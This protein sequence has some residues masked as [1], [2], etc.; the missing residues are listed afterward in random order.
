MVAAIAMS[1]FSSNVTLWSI[2]WP[3]ILVAVSFR[4]SSLMSARS[5]ILVGFAPA[6]GYVRSETLLN[7]DSQCSNE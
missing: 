6:L 4:S 1:S 2:G 3:W 7:S 5:P